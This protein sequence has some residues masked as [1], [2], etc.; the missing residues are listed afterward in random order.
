MKNKGIASKIIDSILNVLIVF[1]VL[2]LFVSMYTA[3]QVKIFKNDYADFFGYSMFEIQTGS[4]H[5]AI[6]VGDWIIT[7]ST[8]DVKVGDIVTYR[9]GKDYI[10]HRIIESYGGTYVTKGDANTSSDDAIDKSQIVGKVVKILHGFGFFKKTIFNPIVMLLLIIT[11]YLFNLTFKKNKS[12]LDIKLQG[13]LDNA[14]KSILELIGKYRKTPIKP[15]K[16][17]KKK[18]EV[19]AVKI[20]PKEKVEE[21]EDAKEEIKPVDTIVETESN[22]DINPVITEES[23]KEDKEEELSKT[24]L[25]RVISVKNEDTKAQDTKTEEDKEEELSKTSLYRFISVQPEISEEPEEDKEEELSKTSVF[26]TISVDQKPLVYEEEKDEKEAPSNKTPVLEAEE[27]EILDDEKVINKEYIYNLLKSKKAKDVVEKAFIIKKTA[28]DEIMDVLLKPS[29][30]Y[31]LKSNMRASFINYYINCKYCGSDTD[32]KNI[33]ELISGYHNELVKKYAKDENKTNIINAYIKCLYF[34]SDVEDKEK[35]NYE[36]EIK[37]AF[38]YE[39]DVAKYMANDINN[40]MKYSNEFLRELLDNLDTKAFEI[41]YNRFD[42]Q[43]NLYGVILNH[44]ISFNKMYSDYI[45]DKTYNQGIIS[46]DKIAVLLNMLLCRI[47]F[48]LMRYDYCAKYFVY[49]P[50]SLYSKDRKIDKIAAIIDNEY[51]KNHVCFLTKSSN[52]LKNKDDIKRLRKRGYS[53]ACILDKKIDYKNDDMG[54]FYM[55]DYY[56]IDRKGNRD[57]LCKGLP[58]DIVNRIIVDDINKKVG[59]YGDE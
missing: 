8:S 33:K 35:N 19:I 37:K 31:I 17:V 6:E 29:K 44:N 53:F 43:K 7:K 18:E 28:Y 58:R 45:V 48:D 59:D 5:G 41:K 25:F 52:M 23:S 46:E 47:V 38:K 51:S 42:D 54:Y 11:L 14:K 12:K 39:P 2:F 4:M 16:E 9:N 49:F 27:I 40:I 50:E 55:N 26:R 22:S 30:S 24:S 3:I 10:T 32:R 13:L 1:F 21:K 57:E 36:K 56:F 15:K 20:E 34:I